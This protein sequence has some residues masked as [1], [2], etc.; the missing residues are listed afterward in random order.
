MNASNLCQ[1]GATL[2]D[3]P[4]GPLEVIVDLPRQEACGIAIV[5]HPQPLLGGSAMHKIPLF[6]ARSMAE[7]GWIVVRPNFRGVGRSAGTH[8]EGRGET[9]DVLALLHLL[10]THWPDLRLALIGFSFGAFVQARVAR[11]LVDAGTPPWVEG[12]PR[13]GASERA[14][15][16]CRPG[17][18]SF[19][20]QQA[21][22]IAL[23]CPHAPGR[24]NE[25][26][27]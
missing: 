12:S 2:F 18:R 25:T 3:R 11:A 1:G 22:C 19:L 20:H 9:E 5:G 7:A 8:D 27:S 24:V 4:V 21:A 6:L 14:A 23:A 13:L 16:R 10:R 26:A 17:R 15:Y